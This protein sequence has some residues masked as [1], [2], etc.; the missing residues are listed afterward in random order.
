M[1]PPLPPSTA[2]PAPLTAL[3]PPAPLAACNFASLNHCPHAER[4]SLVRRATGSS[5]TTGD[6][7]WAPKRPTACAQQRHMAA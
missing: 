1:P 5:C 4:S 3:M 6:E 7:G 2:R